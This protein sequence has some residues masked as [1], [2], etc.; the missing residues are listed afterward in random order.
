[1]IHPVVSASGVSSSQSPVAV[2]ESGDK[3]EEGLEILL[4]W[5]DLVM[6]KVLGQ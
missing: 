5:E 3:V 2:D 1:M 6:L 4:I